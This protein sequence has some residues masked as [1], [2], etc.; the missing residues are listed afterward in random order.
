MCAAVVPLSWR[1]A[2]MALIT[3]FRRVPLLQAMAKPLCARDCLR[4]KPFHFGGCDACLVGQACSGSIM[5]ASTSKAQ[6]RQEA[7][8]FCNAVSLSSGCKALNSKEQALS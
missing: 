2:A 3:E 5:R 1:I 8:H 6:S 7:Y 4:M